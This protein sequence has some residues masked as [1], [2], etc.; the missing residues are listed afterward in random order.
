[1]Q[2]DPSNT[3]QKASTVDKSFSDNFY[4]LLRNNILVNSGGHSTVEIQ[5]CSKSV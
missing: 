4:L 3:L 5:M 1:M 2:V